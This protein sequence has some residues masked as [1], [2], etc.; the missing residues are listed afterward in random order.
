VANGDPDFN[1]TAPPSVIR[2]GDTIC[3]RGGTYTAFTDPTS[4]AF[5]VILAG[6][7]S[8]PITIRSYPGERAIIDGGLIPDGSNSAEQ[9]DTF[10][11]TGGGYVTIRDL[12]LTNSSTDR[13]SSRPGGF[14]VE[15]PGVKLINNVIHDTGGGIGSNDTSYDAEFYG[16]VIYNVGWDDTY[17]GLRQG[18]T[19]HGMYI[20]NQSGF[21]KIYNNII[22]DSFGYG[23]HAYVGGTAHLINL[24]VQGN[25]SYDNGYWTRI[26]DSSYAA[27]GRCTD[28]FLFGSAGTPVVNLNFANNFGYH[29]EQRGCPNIE[30][31]Y[32][33]GE[34]ASAA[35]TNNVLHGGMNSIARFAT[36]TFTG[37]VVASWIQ[38]M[39]YTPPASAAS[40][41][42]SQNTYYFYRDD[43]LRQPFEWDDPNTGAQVSLSISQWMNLGFDSSSVINPCGIRPTGVRVTLQPNSY[44]ANRTHIVINNFSKNATVSVDVSSFLRPG[45]SF[46]LRNAQDYFGAPVASGTYAGGSIS[47]P[48]ASLTVAR[49]SGWNGAMIQSSS[50]DFGAFVLIKR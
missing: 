3:I 31:G 5:H 8:A 20:Q 50:P 26:Q 23:L 29:R 2:P 4:L 35:A 33:D 40:Q 37:N 32:G 7:P 43:C 14:G 49:P 15:A 39:A 17:T 25:V 44:D 1:G 34:N 27:E 6:T 28:N 11:I 47:I 24:D 36:M 19:G 38:D 13:V 10:I 16:N 45:D 21:K 9:S 18:G 42:F 30:L 46:E 22:T 12:E 41:N 48:M